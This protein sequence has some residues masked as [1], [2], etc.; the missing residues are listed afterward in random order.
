MTSL[1]VW[2]ALGAVLFAVLLR[3]VRWLAEHVPLTWHQQRS[4]QMAVEARYLPAIESYGSGAG[5]QRALSAAPRVVPGT[6][7]PPGPTGTPSRGRR[8]P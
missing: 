2:L 1:L 4:A 6:V 3:G 5:D 7:L 8:R